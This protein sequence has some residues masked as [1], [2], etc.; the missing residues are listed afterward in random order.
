[1]NPIAIAIFALVWFSLAG[2][3][4]GKI[5]CSSDDDC[6]SGRYCRAE[7]CGYDC[8]LDMDCPKGFRCSTKG[9]CERGCSK[10]NSGVEACDD[11]DNDC[12]GQ[13]DEGFGVGDDCVGKGECGQGVVEC[14]NMNSTVCSTM[15]GGSKDQSSEEICNGFDDDCDGQTDEGF[16]VGD[17]C[18]GEGEC[19]QGVVECATP[20][21]TICS[22]M[23][24]GSEDQS[25]EETCNQRDD[26]CD[27]ETDEDAPLVL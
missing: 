21:S 11:V 3:S 27:G 1:M 15:P 16:G 24:G 19:G 13:T 7:Q 17:D 26:D 9:R 20:D 12:D 25:S 18:V 5:Q 6:P 14:A 2:C 23:P 4:G 10:T 8:T 22:T